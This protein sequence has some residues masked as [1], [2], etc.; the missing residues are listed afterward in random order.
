MDLSLEG[1]L[2]ILE[3]GQ[4]VSE[5][6]LAELTFTVKGL[7]FRVR[8]QVRATQSETRIGFRFENLSNRAK[9]Q[10]GDLVEELTHEHKQ[11]LR[12]LQERELRIQLA[13]VAAL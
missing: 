13:R 6:A 2:I 8:G 5:G 9:Q 1:C 7:P 12:R 4:K 3:A 10:L 11:Q